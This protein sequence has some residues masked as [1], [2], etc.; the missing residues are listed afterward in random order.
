MKNV[1]PFKDGEI[2]LIKTKQQVCSR[3][4]GKGELP[5]AGF[6][7]RDKCKCGECLVREKNIPGVNTEMADG[8]L[9]HLSKGIIPGFAD[10]CCLSPEFAKSCQTVDGCSAGMPFQRR[11]AHFIGGD[12]VEID[13]QFAGGYSF[14]HKVTFLKS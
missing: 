11:I 14:E 7:Q 6:I 2:H 4:A 8:V 1:C 5:V 10:K 3:L 9:E 13:Q 12:S